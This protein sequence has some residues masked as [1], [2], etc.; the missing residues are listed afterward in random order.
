MKDKTGVDHIVRR[1]RDYL[2]DFVGDRGLAVVVAVSTTAGSA[3]RVA[4][5]KK[6]GKPGVVQALR[7]SVERL[8]D[9]GALGVSEN[10]QASTP[11]DAS[12]RN[13]SFVC[14][15]CQHPVKATRSG[16]V[17]PNGHG[18][19][20]VEVGPGEVP[21]RPRLE[22][23]EGSWGDLVDEIV[24]TVPAGS[25][26]LN[27]SGGTEVTGHLLDDAP[28]RETV[29]SILDHPKANLSKRSTREK[30]LEAIQRYA[31]AW[32]SDRHT[33]NY[34]SDVRERQSDL[35]TSL[36]RHEFWLADR[37]AKQS[38]KVVDGIRRE[39]DEQLRGA[40]KEKQS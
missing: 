2:C 13:K 7:L 19:S 24:L 5:D 3:V 18:G 15:V 38:K 4:V 17:C 29:Y 33:Q 8:V 40:R 23:L 26:A 10:G 20:E 11:A 12:V 31:D 30:L 35:F 28:A 1:M 22:P 36:D 32:S 27:T 9:S 39:R 21:A 25:I 14:S 34:A 37:F 16:L 6:I